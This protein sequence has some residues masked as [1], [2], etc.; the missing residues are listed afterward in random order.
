MKKYLAILTSIFMVMA[1]M[2][3]ATAASV[4]PEEEW[5]IVVVP[6]EDL[7]PWFVRMKVGVD[8][9]AA[10]TGLNAYQK[11][12]AAIDAAMQVQVVQDMIAQGVDAICVVPIDPAALEPILAD[13]MEKGIVVVTHEGSTQENTM[14]N[15]E[16]FVNRDFGGFLMDNLAKA[17][18]ETGTYTTMVGFLTNASHNE[19]M[20][21]A[22][23]RQ[24]ELYPNMTLLGANPRVESEDNRDTAYQRAKELFKMYPELDGI[25]GSASTDAP[26][27]GRAA[28]ELGIA[29]EFKIVGTG[30]PN[31]NRPYLEGN[32]VSAIALWDPAA[33]GYAMCEMAV[34]ILRNGVDIVADGIDLNQPG[35]DNMQFEA[36]GSKT[37]VGAGWIAIDASNVGEYDF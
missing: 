19:W 30:T 23:A 3:V 20:D 27:S 7:S 34:Q 8:A 29:G 25:V 33:A 9:Y 28:E 11:G 12:P 13:A 26:G 1:L 6:K 5:K 22:I 2:T 21:G 36:P 17:M 32:I 16:A 18:G 4:K 31:E 10:E 37:M 24:Q 15:I 14:V 35:W